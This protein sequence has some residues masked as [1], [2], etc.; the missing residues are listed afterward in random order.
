MSGYDAQAAAQVIA[1]NV[2]SA[3]V[4]ERP[5]LNTIG[6]TVRDI[7]MGGMIR[8]LLR[9]LPTEDGA[10]LATVCNFALDDALS[11]M[12]PGGPRVETIDPDTG[13]ATM[14]LP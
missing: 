9:V 8:A 5:G 13:V 12:D 1:E 3:Y 6:R 14:R 2:I 10:L 4:R 7:A 11:G